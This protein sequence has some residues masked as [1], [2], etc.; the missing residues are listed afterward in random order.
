MQRAHRPPVARSNDAHLR[1]D[2]LLQRALIAAASCNALD[3]R[4]KDLP[5]DI[6]QLYV[7][8]LCLQQRPKLRVVVCEPR[9][10][11]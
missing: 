8:Y 2:S 7:D 9:A 3:G 6:I 10:S 5:V 1:E 11:F 4:L